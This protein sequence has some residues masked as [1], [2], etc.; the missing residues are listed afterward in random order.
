MTLET[1]NYLGYANDANYGSWNIASIA[2]EIFT[3][4][5]KVLSSGGTFLGFAT[6][7]VAYD[8]TFIDLLVE[9]ST[10]GIQWIIVKL[11]S[12]LFV[13]WLNSQYQVHDPIL[14]RKFLWVFLLE[15]HFEFI[16]YIHVPTSL[17]SLADY[18]SNYV[19][20]W[21]ICHTSFRAS[22]EIKFMVL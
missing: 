21:H 19:L 14:F 13:S 4:G 5:N 2:W 1:F 17:N 12:Q 3:P 10:L 16:E 20:D 8:S 11:D 6:I 22:M 18:L 9:A 7:N 15:W